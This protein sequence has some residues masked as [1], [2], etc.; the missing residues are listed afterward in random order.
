MLRRSWSPGEGALG[1]SGQCRLL[2]WKKS[3]LIFSTTYIDTH[4]LAECQPCLALTSNWSFTAWAL[5]Y[6]LLPEYWRNPIPHLQIPHMALSPMWVSEDSEVWEISLLWLVFWARP[7]MSI[8]VC[9]LPFQLS[10]NYFLSYNTY[11][12]VELLALSFHTHPKRSCL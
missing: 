4:V 8:R 3:S 7:H 10:L 11:C 2:A 1:G 9:L 6:L 5:W 12:P